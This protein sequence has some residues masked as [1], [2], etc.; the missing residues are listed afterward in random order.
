MVLLLENTSELG[1]DGYEG[2]CEQSAAERRRGLRI[3]Q[4][5]PI[6][7]FEPTTQRYYGG[8]TEDLSR[9]GLRIELPL[10]TPMRP[11]KRVNIHVG[12]GQLGES[13]ANRRSMMPARVVWVHR[14]P[15]LTTG[16]LTAGIEFIPSIAAHLDAA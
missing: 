10:A 2:A 3:R 1:A 14:D 7:I 4:N 15:H 13:L 8:Q 11:G 6:K 9:T 5:R 16:V 12:L